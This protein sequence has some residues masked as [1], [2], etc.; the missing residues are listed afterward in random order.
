MNENDTPISRLNLTQ[1][2]IADL[3]GVSESLISMVR[4]GTRK[5]SVE[6]RVRLARSL[7]V[8]I[9]DLFSDSQQAA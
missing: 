3:A 1:R 5:P 2:E 6:L 8:R 4:S 7:G 9:R